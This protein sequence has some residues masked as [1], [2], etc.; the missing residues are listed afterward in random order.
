[1][2]AIF[3]Y[4]I[5][6]PISTI[7]GVVVAAMVIG[8]NFGE[9]YLI[10]FAIAGYRYGFKMLALMSIL[11]V[12][13]IAGYSLTAGASVINTLLAKNQDIQLAAQYDI[14]ASKGR[15]EAAK[16]D[17]LKA[18]LEAR[19]K[20]HYGYLNDPSIALAQSS[21]LN[22]SALEN[23]RIA[24]ILRNKAPT[25]KAAFDMSID[26]IAFLVSLALELSIIGVTAFNEIFNKPTALPALVR[27]AN[28]SLDWNVN[29]NQL[30]NLSVE[31]SPSLGTIALPSGVPQVGF[32]GYGWSASRH[33]STQ[34]TPNSE[35]R[36]LALENLAQPDAQGSE[37]GFKRI[38]TQGSGDGS[39]APKNV[40]DGAFSEWL[41][42]IKLGQLSPTTPPTKRFI[43][44]R[45]LAK[46]IKL[47]SGMAEEW[48]ERAFNLGVIELNPV[49]RNG[50]SKYLLA[51]NKTALLAK[52]GSV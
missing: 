25:F 5:F 37:D 44:E 47:I 41:E 40:Q 6:S 21:A 12:L 16:A 52:E 45:N 46:G 11:G 14:A 28:K 17:V 43:S 50:V 27:F 4:N 23:Q 36:N 13:V 15:I 48:Q 31:K 22:A 9:G 35:V 39:L 29:P 51:G 38:G 7:L 30:A 19:E 3:A 42:L 2:G 24:E 33:A 32:S 49:Q 26:A 20:D 10:R 18:Q 8:F 34:D 1:M